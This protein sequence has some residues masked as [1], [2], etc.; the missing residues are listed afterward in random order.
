MPRRELVESQA[1]ELDS[2]GSRELESSVKRARRLGE[3]EGSVVLLGLNAPREL[4]VKEL[5]RGLVHC[6]QTELRS[7]T[8]FE[9][10]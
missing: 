5:A 3:F 1:I 10:Y 6:R 7:R 8:R 4:E 2:R 9:Y